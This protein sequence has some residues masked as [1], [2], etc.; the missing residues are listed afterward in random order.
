MKKLRDWFPDFLNESDWFSPNTYG[1]E[2][3]GIPETPGVYFFVADTSPNPKTN[4][5]KIVYVG[6]SKNLFN[7]LRNHE[8]FKVFSETFYNVRIFFHETPYYIAKERSIIKILAPE[9]NSHKYLLLRYQQI[10]EQQ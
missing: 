8:L 3:K 10:P 4:K 2:Y 5:P 9:G 7:R 1:N 6:S